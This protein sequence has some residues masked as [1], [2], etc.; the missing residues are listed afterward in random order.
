MKLDNT[1]Y[2]KEP[3]FFIK[4]KRVWKEFH[5]INKYN[6]RRFVRYAGDI[7]YVRPSQSIC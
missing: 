1:F 7:L 3:M 4:L 2:N 6:P 5:V